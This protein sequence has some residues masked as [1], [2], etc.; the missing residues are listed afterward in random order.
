LEGALACP[1]A[2]RRPPIDRH[3]GAGFGSRPRLAATTYAEG[4]NAILTPACREGE[5]SDYPA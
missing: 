2:T 5:D 3:D 4:S 1:P